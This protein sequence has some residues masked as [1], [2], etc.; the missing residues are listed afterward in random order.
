MAGIRVFDGRVNILGCLCELHK[1]AF[2]NR[3]E[4]ILESIFFLSLVFFSLLLSFFVLPDF[5]VMKFIRLVQ[6]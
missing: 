1:S 3:F 2:N 4:L 6:C 5:F